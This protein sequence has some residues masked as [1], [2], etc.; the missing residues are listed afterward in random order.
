[1]PLFLSLY[2]CFAFFRRM[3]RLIR[4]LFF[5]EFKADLLEELKPLFF[6][7]VMLII[8]SLIDAPPAQRWIIIIFL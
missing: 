5:S 8:S 7:D 4:A 2:F 3:N 6:D 1:M